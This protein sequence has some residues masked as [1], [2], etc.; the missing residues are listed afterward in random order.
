MSIPVKKNDD[1]KKKKM[2]AT[3]IKKIENVSV[4]SYF[5]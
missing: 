4:Q 1:S 2:S 5:Y 3:I